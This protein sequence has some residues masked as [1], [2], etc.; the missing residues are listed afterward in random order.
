VVPMTRLASVLLEIFEKLAWQKSAQFQ[1]QTTH[2][3]EQ[4]LMRKNPVP[5][6]ILLHRNPAVQQH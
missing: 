4:I 1:I 3:L 6:Q 5:E 2:T